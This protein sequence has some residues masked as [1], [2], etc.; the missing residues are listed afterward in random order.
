[1]KVFNNHRFLTLAASLMGIICLVACGQFGPE[2]MA[3]RQGDSSP[4]R[5]ADS[6]N[7]QDRGR[8][9][10]SYLVMFREQRAESNLFFSTFREEYAHHYLKLS[11]MLLSDNRIKNIEILSAI[12]MSSLRAVEWEPEF[13]APKL[14]S[15]IFDGAADDSSAGVL[16][17]VDFNSEASAKELLET[18]EA[19]QRIWFAEPN[20]VSRLS[21]G[22]L[23]KWSTDYEAFQVWYKEINLQNALK[24][25]GSGTAEGA[26]SEDAILSANTLIAVL[27]SGVDYEHPQLKDNIWENAAIGAAG[28]SDDLH[29]CNTTAP[30]KGSLG[31]GEVW[32]N[33]ASGPGEACGNGAENAK[34][35]HGTHVAGII[36][37]KPTASSAEDKYG[38]VCPICKVMILKVAEVEATDT[39]VDLKILDDSQIRAFKYLTRFRKSGGSAV[40]LIN[41]SFG[42]YNRSRSQAI[43]IDVLK[44]VG[45]GTL[46]IAAASNEDSVIRSYPAAFANAI[47]VASVGTASN[48]DSV[49]KSYFSNYGSWVDISAPGHQILSSISGSRAGLQSGTSMAAPV[50]AGAAGLL[51]AAFPTLTFNELKERILNSANA[52]KLYGGGKDGEVNVQYYYPKV[53]GESTRRPLLGGGY[54]DAD[55]MLK[56]GVNSAT[57]QPMDRV[58]AG[59]AII[60]GE[61]QRSNPRA[62]LAVIV[63]PLLVSVIRRRVRAWEI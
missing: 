38:G 63:I 32:P 61:H 1:M 7:S 57:G 39:S 24:D 9:P 14:L 45:T 42:K 11:E 29:G 31:N 55:A 34:C 40:R 43:L 35:N 59:C 54:V 19:E 2:F 6:E 3:E 10:G 56:K 50:V 33:Q 62:L 47:A 22:E 49:Q 20:E 46:V 28:C 41:A 17:R 13:S 21:A 58:T 5:F 16:T 8:V 12:D 23:N 53:S 44:R 30:S 36:A 52:S 37:A 26:Q 48:Q 51:L 18:W 27:D 15:A 60:S 4:L 25:L